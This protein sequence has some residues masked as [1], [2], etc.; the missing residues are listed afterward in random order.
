MDRFVQYQTARAMREASNK[1][2][3]LAALGASFA[4]GRQ[5]ADTVGQASAKEENKVE[6]LRE[7]KKSCL[8]KAS[9]AKWNLRK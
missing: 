5:M 1:D 8:M 6:K 2:G 3:G 9:S 7:Y 4:F